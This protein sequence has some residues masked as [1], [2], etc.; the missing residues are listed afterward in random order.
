MSTKSPVPPSRMLLIP[1]GFIIWSVAFVTLYAT[2]AIGCEFGWPEGVQRGLLVAISLGFLG[3]SA[4]AG[5]LVFAHWRAKARLERAP[6][7]ALSIL[8]IYGLGSAFVAMIGLAI[9]S[10]TTSLCI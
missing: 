1:L 4:L 9:P 8:G 7:P 2:N 10:L 6:A 3:G 5:W